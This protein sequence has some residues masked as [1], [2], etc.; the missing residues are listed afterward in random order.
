MAFTSRPSLWRQLWPFRAGAAA[1]TS[2]SLEFLA[3]RA[4]GGKSPAGHVFLDPLAI[5][6]AFAGDVRAHAMNEAVGH[7]P[8]LTV[9]TALHA[10][11]PDINRAIAMVMAEEF[12]IVASGARFFGLERAGP[13]SRACRAEVATRA[14]L[15]L[16][17]VR[18]GAI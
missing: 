4:Q 13:L 17:L 11:I 3:Q 8:V 14:A 7:S 18:A 16:T 15:Y 10:I 1:H 2:R 9:I 6:R 12:R 5:V